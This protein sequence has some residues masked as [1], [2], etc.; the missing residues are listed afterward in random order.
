M[1]LPLSAKDG[2]KLEAALAAGKKPVLTVSAMARD[3]YGA[4]VP[5]ELKVT[6]RG[7][8]ARRRYCVGGW[9]APTLVAVRCPVSAGIT[10]LV[11]S[12]E[13][14][15]MTSTGPGSVTTAVPRPASEA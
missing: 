3:G 11:P 10:K 8:E 14:S 5:L 6:A 13:V 1:M 15:Q 4:K 7:A 2:A 9:S 12:T